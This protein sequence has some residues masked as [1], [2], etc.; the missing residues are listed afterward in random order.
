VTYSNVLHE[1]LESLHFARLKLHVPRK[2]TG[3]VKKTDLNYI[4][5]KITEIKT[6][7]KVNHLTTTKG[8]KKPGGKDE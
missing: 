8:L 3:M 7:I 5:D 6:G 2:A 4:I 1:F